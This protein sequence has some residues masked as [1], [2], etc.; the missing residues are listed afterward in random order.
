MLL[1]LISTL[2]TSGYSDDKRTEA[3][4]IWLK[5]F[6]I[7]E[8][9]ELNEKLGKYDV[10]LKNYEDAIAFF[11][12]VQTN[13]PDWNTFLIDY[14]IKKCIQ[15]IDAIKP[16][17]K[18]TIEEQIAPP[19][20][21]TSTPQNTKNLEK[22][23]ESLRAEL[24]YSKQKLE[25][26]MT[27]L[28]ES[29]KEA[30]R[31]MAAIE[32]LRRI[33]TEKNE[34][35]KR[36]QLLSIQLKNALEKTAPAETDAEKEKL[37]KE[38]SEFSAKLLE[39]RKKEKEFFDAKEILAKENAELKLK[40][41]ETEYKA[42]EYEISMRN[43][44]QRISDTN[45]NAEALKKNLADMNE[46]CARLESELEKNR[47]TFLETKTK[48]DNLS[49]R[50]SEIL[51][52]NE[53]GGLTQELLNENKTLSI[54][55]KTQT[56]ALDQAIHE[57]EKLIKTNAELVSKNQR[58]ERVM[59]EQSK[60]IDSYLSDNKSLK[61]KVDEYKSSAD[62]QKKDINGLTIEKLEQQDIIKQLN[63]KINTFNKKDADYT[64][65]TRY[66]SEVDAKNRELVAKLKTLE[67][68]AKNAKEKLNMSD[69]EKEETQKNIADLGA[70]LKLETEKHLNI[71]TEHA[72]IKKALMHRNSDLELAKAEIKKLQ[73]QNELFQ[74]DI[75]T[76]KSKDISHDDIKDANKELFIEIKKAK[77]EISDKSDENLELN[78]DIT[79][80][81]DENERLRK[82][83]PDSEKL[84][85]M[86]TEIDEKAKKLESL[87]EEVD[88]LK[89]H[90][91]ALRSRLEE[92][93]NADTE[94]ILI[95]RNSELELAKTEIKKLLA[96]I[97]KINDEIS[98][99]SDENLEL[100]KKFAKLKNENE[101]L[102]NTTPDSAKLD[103]MK[104]EIDENA[105]KLASLNKELDKLK[106]HNEAL[107]NR[108]EEK[109]VDSISPK[110][111]HDEKAKLLA[112]IEN[113]NMT[114]SKLEK[115][116]FEKK[117]EPKTKKETS[118]KTH[119]QTS[120][121]DKTIFLISAATE[122][123]K[124]KDMESAIWHYQKV[125]EFDKDNQ[126]AIAGLARVFAEKGDKDKATAY[127]KNIS[128]SKIDSPD[129]AI[130][131]ARTFMQVSPDELKTIKEYYSKALE[132][133]A[134]EDAELEKIRKD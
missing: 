28:A 130:S 84:D 32:E 73:E 51:E 33:N 133:G 1:V 78:K 124:N 14:R 93:D 74:K 104:T 57:Q 115:E 37:K 27:S 40:N 4:R 30:T 46:K 16:L 92:I 91:E 10:A 95:N 110:S 9:A 71:S 123:E 43:T 50:L 65:L 66:A 100:N 105:K 19:P 103:D 35:E 31:G 96:Q 131:V 90:N 82:M 119:E 17:C 24:L 47:K 22:M 63:E 121:N 127:L 20:S 11:R 98:D 62:L 15:Q 8:K 70:N 49:K 54:Q 41:T 64:E 39:A 87:H 58:D 94:K 75:E 111:F 122:A 89:N 26:A 52:T 101:R 86:K 106:N 12:N 108:L 134:K 97:K 60:K 5:G 6:E 120:Q 88:K 68:D 102:R 56:D 42:K 29:R 114:I 3:R 7:Y 53:T 72:D 21:K 38:L 129:L 77:N 83:I 79:K 13:Y 113:K 2:T 55:V 116:L 81:K 99:K 61:D 23:A 80:L 59:A 25:S 44:E 18:K 34:L 112:E 45:K 85:D 48:N 118:Q 132:L 109:V 67:D 117:N 125:F 36:Y 128:L 69:K 76:R 126:T 107:R